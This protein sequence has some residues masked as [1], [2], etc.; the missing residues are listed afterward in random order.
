LNQQNGKD[1]LMIKITKRLFWLLPIVFIVLSGCS[2]SSDNNATSSSTTTDN[3]IVQLLSPDSAKKAIFVTGISLQ[4]KTTAQTGSIYQVFIEPTTNVGV[5]PFTTSWKTNPATSA[6]DIASYSTGTLSYLT[7]YAWRV[8][9]ILPSGSWTDSAI[10]YFQTED[11]PAT[12]TNSIKVYDYKTQINVTHDVNILF[13][14]LDASGV[15]VTGLTLD[16]IE[17]TEDGEPLRESDLKLTPQ[18]ASKINV[19]IHILIDNSSSVTGTSNLT[20][21]KADAVYIVNILNSITPY[22]SS[23]FVYEF[24]ENLIPKGGSMATGVNATEAISEINSIVDGV[25]STDFN[26]AVADVGRSMSNIFMVDN[27]LQNMMIVLSDGDDTAG[28]RNLSEATSA[29]YGKRVYTMGYKGDLR[30]DVLKTIGVSGYMNSEFGSITPFL[31]NIRSYFNNFSLSFYQLTVT[32]PKRGFKNH[33][34][35][36]RM[37]GSLDAVNVTYPGW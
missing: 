5:A 11:V 29:V 35:S 37:R 7:W 2:F 14:M 22:T 19:P 21:M 24:S 4:W 12:A 3:S 1:F 23:F 16:E 17:V 20:R 28:K 25:K 10:R 18:D 8:R 26:G 31:S 36:I 9:V 6:T 15:G 34:I 33:T 32:S 13:Q 27:I 30:E